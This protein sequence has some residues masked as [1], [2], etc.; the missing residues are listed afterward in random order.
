MKKIVVAL[1][2]LMFLFCKS[3]AQILIAKAYTHPFSDPTKQDVFNISL[4]GKSLLKGTVTFKIVDFMGRQIF[5]EKY[6]SEDFLTGETDLRSP[7]QLAN[8]LKAQIDHFFDAKNFALP[9][10][11]LADRYDSDYSDKKTWEDI[12]AERTATGFTYS[13]GYEGTY[14]IAWS[15][16]Q[17]K[18]VVYFS[19][20]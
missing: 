9:A 4:V 11:S 12:K 10:I 2:L 16:K 6:P 17:K 20:D 8:K 13:H 1:T 19:I 15:K 18:V 5:I 14:S 7:K 3:D